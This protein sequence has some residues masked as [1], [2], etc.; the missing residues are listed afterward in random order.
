VGELIGVNKLREFVHSLI[1]TGRLKGVQPVSAMII[2]EPE[3]GKTSIVVEKQ[4][5]A[6]MIMTD[7][8]G[9]GLQLLC[10]MNPRT[11]HFVINDMGVIGGHSPKTQ[12]YFYAMLMAMTEEGIRAVA[13]P[14][15][16]EAAAKAGRRGFIGCITT[17]Q[18]TDKRHSW[19]K[20]GLARRIVPFHFD[21][22]NELILKI[23]TEI[24]NGHHATFESEQILKVPEANIEVK[25]PEKQSAQI[26]AIADLRSEKLNQLG[27]S[28]LKNYRSLA[29]GHALI[30]TWKNPT[31]SDN[32]VEFL[33]RIDP[34]VNWKEPSVL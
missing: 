24:D 3:R 9:K 4:C 31:V 1:L 27:I 11:T 16:V 10:Q 17:S 21:Y 34:Y 32:D 33:K 15:G 2:A 26:R 6:L 20:R 23:K 5:E 14:D 25:L 29:M 18:A 30:K 13:N 19:H 8:T 22:S 28:L 7:V 12:N